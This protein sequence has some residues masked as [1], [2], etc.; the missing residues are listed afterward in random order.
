M[1]TKRNQSE[2]ASQGSVLHEIFAKRKATLK[3]LESNSDWYA[4]IRDSS[5]WPQQPARRFRQAF[6]PNTAGFQFRVIAEIKRA[7]PSHGLFAGH[8]DP[9]VTAKSYA[10]HGATA[11][12]VLTEPDYFGGNVSYIKAIRAELPDMPI[13][14]KDF[15]FC[16][17]QVYLARSVGAD[18][19]LL[20]AAY[21]TKRRLDELYQLAHSLGLTTL[22]EVHNDEELS[23]IPASA[24]AASGKAH[25]EPREAGEAANSLLVGVNTRDLKDLSISLS[26]FAPLAQT[27]RQHPIAQQDRGLPLIAESGI[28]DHSDLLALTHQGAKGFLVGSALMATADPGK[29]LAELMG[30]VQVSS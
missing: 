19:V 22:V 7:S 26:R 18:A 9:V 10:A 2:G 3:E 1:T 8:H 11:L 13:L 29:A 24:L 5:S 25:E 30:S 15:F 12:S 23:K 27:I 20:I 6:D 4:A 14:M 17:S 21:L 16:E 28:N